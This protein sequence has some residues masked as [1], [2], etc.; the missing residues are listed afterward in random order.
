[1]PRVAPFTLLLCMFVVPS[2]PFPNPSELKRGG[3]LH[4]KGGARWLRGPP[5]GVVVLLVISLFV[6]IEF[7][8]LLVSIELLV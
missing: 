3:S 7:D 4:P 8:S 2:P 1:M 5:E 6:H